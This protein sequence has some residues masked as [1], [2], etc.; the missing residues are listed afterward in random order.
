M[1]SHL[2][3]FFFT[4]VEDDTLASRVGD[5]LL[6]PFRYLFHGRDVKVIMTRQDQPEV[7]SCPS[8]YGKDPEFSQGSRHWMKAILAIILLAPATLCGLAAKVISYK[9]PE[10]RERHRLAKI[11]LT[12]VPLVV[13]GQ[14]SPVELENDLIRTCHDIFAGDLFHRK[15]DT[16]VIHGRDHLELSAHIHELVQLKR[17]IIVNG[18]I[19]P[20]ELDN[21]L[22]ASGKWLVQKNRRDETDTFIKQV[23]AKSVSEAAKAKSPLRSWLSFGKRFHVVYTTHRTP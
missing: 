15:V 5:N 17:L 6:A 20:G 13:I 4:K 21:S 3:I 9:D 1:P 8:F 18:R 23:H 14:D 2:K 12:R 16:L 22:R 19:A 11:H 7:V 10:V